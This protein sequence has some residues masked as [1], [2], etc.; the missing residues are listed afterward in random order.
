MLPRLMQREC[1]VLNPLGLHARPAAEFVRKAMS[2]ES[3]A[4]LQM[5]RDNFP[6]IRFHF[7]SEFK[8]DLTRKL[9]LLYI[10]MTDFIYR[11]IPEPVSLHPD[12]PAYFKQKQSKSFSKRKIHDHRNTV[13][14]Q[15]SPTRELYL[16]FKENLPYGFLFD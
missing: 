16:V 2:L 9:E 14:F 11:P 7:T 5:V 12:W 8:D 3:K 4:W 1:T 13:D 15:C 10:I 6:D